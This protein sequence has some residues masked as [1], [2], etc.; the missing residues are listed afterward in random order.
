MRVHVIL[1]DGAEEWAANSKDD[2]VRFYL[3]ISL[4]HQSNIRKVRVLPQSLL[5]VNQILLVVIQ[6][7]TK[8]LRG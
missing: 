1:Q 6:L 3:M 7:Q 4:T 5:R 8:L 2:Y